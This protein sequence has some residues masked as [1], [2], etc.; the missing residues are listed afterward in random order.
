MGNGSFDIV[1][2]LSSVIYFSF[3]VFLWTFIKFAILE[4]SGYRVLLH[5]VTFYG[6]GF[7]SK[8]TL[9][10]PWIISVELTGINCLKTDLEKFTDKIGIDKN[11]H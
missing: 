4:I 3:F 6:M 8:H 5:W 1:V 11:R 7:G 9:Y 10:M 2:H